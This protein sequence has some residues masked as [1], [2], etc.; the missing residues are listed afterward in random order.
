MSRGKA[1]VSVELGV[2]VCVLEDQY[3]FVLHHRVLWRESDVEVAQSMV[4][5]AQE[6]FPDLRLCSF[7][8]NFHSPANRETLD[9]ML[10]HNVLPKKGRCSEADRE[11]ETQPNVRRCPAAASRG[12]VVHQQFGA[13]RL[14][15]G[16][17]LRCGGL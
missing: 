1:G 8:R 2:P 10:Q 3:Q 16:A 17:H 4:G 14:G 6:R 15:S 11:R 12:R 7:D 13:S 9:E 5:E